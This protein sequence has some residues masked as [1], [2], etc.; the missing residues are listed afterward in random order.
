MKRHK[1]GR[2]EMKDFKERKKVLR[3]GRN[4]TNKNMR[5]IQ[6]RSASRLDGTIY[7]TSH[8]FHSIR[9]HYYTMSLISLDRVIILQA[10]KKK[11][12]CYRK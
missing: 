9:V 1:E 10:E 12:D 2:E 4:P 8:G 5:E 3:K 7:T 6:K 11:P